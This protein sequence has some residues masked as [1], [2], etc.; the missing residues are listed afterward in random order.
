MT[1][2]VLGADLGGTSIKWGIVDRDGNA[3]H[4]DR[5]PLPDRK[6]DTVAGLL[7]DIV[8]EG[9]SRTKGKLSGI[10]IGSPGLIDREGRIVRVSPNFPE[11]KDV[12]LADLVREAAGDT[13]VLLENDANLLVYSETRWGAAKGMTD[14]VCLTLGTGVGGGVMTGGIVLRGAGGGAAELGHVPLTPDGPLCGCGNL[15]CLEAYCNIEATMRTAQEVY[16]PETSPED[17]AGLS[18]AAETG[19]ELARE[20]W[21]RIGGWLGLA[22]GGFVNMFNPQVVLIGGGLSGAGEWLLAP[23]R[24]VAAERAYTPNWEQTELKL[25]GLRHRSGLLGAAAL[26]FTAAEGRRESR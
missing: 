12:P 3:V 23:A 21:R 25:A 18:E 17:P 1:D 10:G 8:R 13:P 9:F 22:V 14:I 16:F 15:G 6:S 24:E 26:A 5:V 20:V 4:E 7:R 19:D 2:K 11:W